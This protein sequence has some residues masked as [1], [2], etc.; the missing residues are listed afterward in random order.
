METNDLGKSPFLVYEELIRYLAN[1]S[2]EMKLDMY[3]SAS[4]H[5]DITVEKVE[6]A[7]ANVKQGLDVMLNSLLPTQS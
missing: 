2:N 5:E 4:A 6:K 7:I 3:A 1:L